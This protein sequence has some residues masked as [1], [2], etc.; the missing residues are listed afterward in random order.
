MIIL[1]EIPTVIFQPGPNSLLSHPPH[2]PS[3]RPAT[4]PHQTN[5]IPPDSVARSP[6]S[7]DEMAHT[8]LLANRA[9][10]DIVVHRRYDRFGPLPVNLNTLPER[11]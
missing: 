1:N 6:V 3:R 2:P 8:E 10:R 11:W 5:Q 7:G 4:S 9:L